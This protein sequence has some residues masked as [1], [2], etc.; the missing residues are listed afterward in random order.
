[1]RSI[2][3]MRTICTLFLLALSFMLLT[4]RYQVAAWYPGIQVKSFKKW[5]AGVSV[6]LSLG[7]PISSV[8]A[9]D[10]L[11]AASKAM[12]YS[13]KEKVV[14]DR[15]FDSLPEGAKKRK[16]VALCKGIVFPDSFINY[17]NKSHF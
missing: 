16:A 6:G 4:L 7:A 17:T 15:A 1:M 8:N 10:A 13:S 12:L 9:N 14:V 11:D 5:V 3:E 2:F